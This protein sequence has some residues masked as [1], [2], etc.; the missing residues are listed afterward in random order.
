MHSPLCGSARLCMDQYVFLELLAMDRRTKA[1]A[2][3]N[4]LWF[5]DLNSTASSGDD[6]SSLTWRL[7][8]PRT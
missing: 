3:I 7:S 4:K 2:F 1:V 6:N 5:P 8:T